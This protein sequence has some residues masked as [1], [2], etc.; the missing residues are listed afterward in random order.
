MDN[1][2]TQCKDTDCKD[3]DCKDTQCADTDCK[4]EKKIDLLEAIKNIA[5]GFKKSCKFNKEP[6]RR[7]N[8]RDEDDDD[9][10]SEDDDD[11]EGSQDE[12]SQKWDAF[13]I[14]VKSHRDL[15][16]AFLKML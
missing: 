14:L 7:D 15:C 6:S 4:E 10:G 2:D 12:E 9:D 3:T 8:S 16:D 11:E 5:N 1:K 13:I